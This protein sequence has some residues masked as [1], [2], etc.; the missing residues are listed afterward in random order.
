MKLKLHKWASAATVAF[1]IAIPATLRADAVADWNAIAERS[2]VTA[3]HPPPVASLDFAIVHAA[4]YDG[5]MAID[6]RYQPYYVQIPNASGSM[7]AACAKAGHDILVYLFPAQSGQ[8]DA[9][10][11]AYLAQHNISPSDPGVAVGAQAAA[12]IAALRS[13]DG[14]FPPSPPPYFGNTGT[15]QWRPTPSY[16]PGGPP[17]NAPGL[18][19]WVADVRPFTFNDVADYTTEGPAALTSA[20]YTAD[21]NEV[22]SMGSKTSTARTAAQTQI[23][24]FWA[25][26]GPLMWQ[27]ALR[28]I[29]NRYLSNIGDSAR[30]FALADLAAGDAQIACWSTKYEFNFWRPISAITLADQDGNPA[31]QADPNWRPLINTPNFPEYVSGHTT[32]SEAIVEILENLFGTKKLEFTIT[33]A[34]GLANP[35]TQTYSNLSDAIRDVVDARIYAGIHYRTSDVHGVTLGKRIAKHAFKHYLRAAQ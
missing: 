13:N 16:E 31:T 18:T 32:S 15:G 1:F 19:P 26:S 6:G 34:N 4:I 3:A 30:M 28:D 24:Y 29:S 14:R 12:G 5:I 7:D 22:K 21:F 20:E 8:L 27:R 33:T 23:A 2:V 35:K 17:S 11:N 9:D 10:Y 25:D